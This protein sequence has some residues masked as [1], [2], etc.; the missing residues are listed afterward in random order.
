MKYFEIFRMINCI[1]FYIVT[2][3]DIQRISES[4]EYHNSLDALRYFTGSISELKDDFLETQVV[5]L[6][7]SYECRSPED[8]IAFFDKWP[9]YKAAE[10]V[11]LVII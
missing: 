7:D 3:E 11:K 2:T 8:V 9:H 6:F 5:R 1:F 4:T 10:G